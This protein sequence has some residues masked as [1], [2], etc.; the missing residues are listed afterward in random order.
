MKNAALNDCLL[1]L[2]EAAAHLRIHPRTLRAYVRRGL[3]S[4]RVIGR[5]WKF[6]REDLAT[7]IESA[8]S[9]WDSQGNDDDGK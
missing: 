8:P 9:R 5:R 4:G 3:L 2:T 7:L 6:R 1:T